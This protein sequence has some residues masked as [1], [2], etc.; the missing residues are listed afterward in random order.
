[1]VRSKGVVILRLE[2]GA[3]ITR[4]GQPSRSNKEASSVTLQPSSL[5]RRWAWRSRS[6]PKPWGVWAPQSWLRSGVPLI[7]PLASTCLIVSVTRV[8]AITASPART[9][10]PQRAISSGSTRQRAPSWINTSWAPAGRASRPR[11]TDSWRVSPPSI[12]TTG[13]SGWAAST[14]ARIAAPSTG[15]PTRPIQLIS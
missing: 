4:T 1:M 14:R 7:V 11:L 6:T 2:G 12:Q 13:R 5:A 15:W 8:A 9:A 3:S 10:A